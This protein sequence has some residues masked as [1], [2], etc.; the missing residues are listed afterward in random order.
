MSEA[1]ADTVA[2]LPVTVAPEVGAVTDT[3]GGVVSG[4]GAAAAVVNVK[5][6]EVARFPAASPTRRPTGS[7][8]RSNAWR[9]GAWPRT[10]MA[11]DA[12]ASTA[13]H[14]ER[15]VGHLNRKNKCFC[16]CSRW[17]EIARST[18]AET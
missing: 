13:I 9:A 8:S 17:V 1:E 15:S 4:G 3:V 10:A 5:L 14:A 16:G 18:H 11:T 2:A 12:A 7:K 6:P